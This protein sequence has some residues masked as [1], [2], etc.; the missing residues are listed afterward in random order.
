MQ[1]VLAG[2]LAGFDRTQGPLCIDSICRL[3]GDNQLLDQ[4]AFAILWDN[5][6][7]F[8]C[9]EAHL[10]FRIASHRTFK[11]AFCRAA[12]HLHRA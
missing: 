12:M 1:L 7:S 2:P 4:P 11:P 8:T 10:W 3:K 6:E 9:A 5:G